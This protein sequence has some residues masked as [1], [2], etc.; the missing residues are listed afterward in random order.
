MYQFV[1]GK[2]KGMERETYNAKELAAVLGCSESKAYQ[3]IR[4]MNEELQKAGYLTLRGKVP[5]AY[6]RERFFGV[7]HGES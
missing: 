1:N 6:A 2:E 3:F 4:V 5:V 7:A